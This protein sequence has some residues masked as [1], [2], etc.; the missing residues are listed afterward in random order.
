MD[1]KVE[2]NNVISLQKYLKLDKMTLC[3]SDYDK[4]IHVKKKLYKSK[5]IFPKISWF[6]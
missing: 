6:L 5:L 2:F 3:R 4:R 1:R